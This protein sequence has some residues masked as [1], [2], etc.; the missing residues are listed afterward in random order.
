MLASPASSQ[1]ALHALY[2]DHR[3]WLVG[4]LRGRL[5][6]AH[7][8]ADV[9]QDTF[10]RLL[11][12]GNDPGQLRE[13]R[14]WLRTIAQGLVVDQVRRRAIE[15]AYLAALG[16]LP[17]PL[18]ASPEEQLV[19]LEALARVD[20]LLNGLGARARTAFLL[21]RIEGLGYGQIAER[22]GCCL[23]S[24]EKYM[25]TAIRHCVAMQASL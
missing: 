25:A 24:V 23:S 13:P 17:E 1:L 15:S 9:A 14:A 21:S 10:V 7:E 20:A 5:G 12:R 3:S 2:R 4:W 18:V 22:L 19:T 16:T 6:C 11:V 8:A